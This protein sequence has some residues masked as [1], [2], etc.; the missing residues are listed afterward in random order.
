ML[1]AGLDTQ[2]V[3]WLRAWFRYLRQTGSSFG[4]VTIVDALRRAPAA[5]RALIDLFITAHDPEA[6]NRDKDVERI[7]EQL[8]GALAKVRSIDDD[9]I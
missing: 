7:R 1:Y 2:S 3:V 4:L 9:R 6:K 8:D 5:T